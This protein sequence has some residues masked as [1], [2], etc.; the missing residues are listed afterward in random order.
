L[1]NYKC[2]HFS[3]HGFLHPQTSALSA[4]VLDQLDTTEEY[5]GYV[6]AVEWIGYQ[7]KSDL[8]VLS[9][10][11][12]GLGK[13]V[14]GEGIMGLPY[15]LYLAG[16]KNTLMTLWKV[17][18][19][20]TAEFMR[21]FFTKLNNGTSHIQSL[22]ETKREFMQEEKYKNPRYWAAFVLYGV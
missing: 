16:N 14:S 13:T 19:A 8:M 17:D 22:I 6:T 4:L 10:C 15:A 5:D 3:T 2:L 21:R 7:L 12:T 18:D 20:I 9:A 1:S 11:Q